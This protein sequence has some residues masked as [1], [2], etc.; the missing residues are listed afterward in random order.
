MTG[1]PTYLVLGAGRIFF[2]R[3]TPGT[4]I[5]EGE[6]WLGNVTDFSINRDLVF[7]DKYTSIA[8]ARSIEKSVPIEERQTFRI[9][10]DA[11][12]IANVSLWFGASDSSDIRS[13]LEPIEESLTVRRGR[14]YQLG[15][16]IRPF[17]GTQHVDYV[18]VKKGGSVVP[19]SNYDLDK[20]SGRIQILASA[21]EIADSDTISV[22]FQVRAATVLSVAA[23]TS[24]RAV[25]GSLRFVG[26]NIYGPNK[27]YFFPF[28]KIY[29]GRDISLVQST[30]WQ[31]ID[32]NG[33]AY[34]I[35]AFSPFHVVDD[36]VQI[37][38]TFDEESIIDSGIS[39]SEFSILENLLDMIVNV[40]MPND[41]A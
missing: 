11:I 10:C 6:I 28:V 2:D 22:S 29:A 41:F 12:N 32:F 16:S 8:G 17:I 4:R 30:Q 13:A 37:G 19:A 25:E 26:E 15:L 3:F 23:N 27:T 36:Y 40:D 35:S 20:K 18:T 31:T 38:Y 7:I 14:Y 21:V 1:E 33:E 9:T 24:V 39:L 5:G 34:R